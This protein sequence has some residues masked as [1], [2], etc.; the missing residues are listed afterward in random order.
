MSLR[1]T[2]EEVDQKYND[3]KVVMI[4][5]NDQEIGT[6]G[7]VEAH[8]DP[9]IR[10]RAFSLQLYRM[11]DGKYEL[12]LQQR[13]VG[14]P[15]F[16]FFWANTCCYNMAPGEKYIERAVT[17]VKEEMGVVV[18]ESTLRELYKFSYYAPDV[19][20][21]CENELDTVIVGECPPSSTTSEGYEDFVKLNPDEAMGSRWVGWGE[22]NEDIDKNP[23]KYAPWFKIIVADLRFR[24]VFE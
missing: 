1:K 20:G 5:E 3:R 15:V 8:R 18:G 21:W 6:T 14:K 4:D 17:R 24:S 11:R 12:L 10:H 16:P 23:D 13:A 7:L 2:V 22:L 9:G 19:E